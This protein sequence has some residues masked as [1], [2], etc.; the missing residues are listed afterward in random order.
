M[1]KTAKWI[2]AILV[3]VLMIAGVW[4]YGFKLDTI[5]ERQTV[6]IGVSAPLTGNLAF[7]GE[8]YRN[9]ILMAYEDLKKEKELKHDYKFVFED[10]Q[11]EAVKAA[12]TVNKLISI[13]QAHALISAGS[14]VGNTISPIA[15]RSKV[16][17]IGLAS[18]PTTA[19]GEY[20]FNHW[21]PPYEEVKLLISELQKRGIKN[22]ALFEQNQPGVLVVTKSLQEQLAKTDIKLVAEGK[23]NTGDRDFK[24]VITKV[25]NQAVDA[26]LYLLLTTSPELEILVK[27]LREAGVKQSITSIES[28]GFS[29]NPSLF[30]GEWYIDGADQQKWYID[31][32]KQAYP[33]QAPKIGGGN[34]YDMAKML[35]LAFENVKNSQDRQT[36]IDSAR[37]Y[38]ANLKNFD[39]AMGDNL[40]IDNDGFIITKASVKMIKDGQIISAE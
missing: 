25:K 19:I 5:T 36:M 40:S 33:D 20:N 29:D 10:D 22:I 32:Y 8:S 6:V 39:G 34:G 2:I 28:F 9:S 26:D 11:F 12:T 4:Y 17:H 3:L 15:E 27:Q 37:N 23:F 31:A 7:L 24:T 18:D 38:L 35:I 13:D 14:P 21:T 16:I 30:E 1:S